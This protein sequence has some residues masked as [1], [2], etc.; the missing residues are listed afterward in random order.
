MITIYLDTSVYNRPFDDQTQPRICLETLA[1]VTIMQLVEIDEIILATSSVL[2]F[3][4]RNNPFQL[5]QQWVNYCLNYAKQ[6]QTIDEDIQNRAKQLEYEGIKPMDALHIASAELMNCDY[7]LTSDDRLLKRY[8]SNILQVK[9]PV[10]FILLLTEP[11][12]ES[13][14][15]E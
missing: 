2:A 9:N 5:R 14:N 10:E 4:N 1:F 12:H 7:F 6:H 13:K 11:N 3:E 15:V 8:K